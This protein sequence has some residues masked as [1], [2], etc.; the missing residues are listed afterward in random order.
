MR[1]ATEITARIGLDYQTKTV[2]PGALFYQ[3]CLPAETLFY[4]LVF[5]NASRHQ[6]HKK[7]AAQIMGYLRENTPP[8]LQVGGDETT[9]KG[10]CVVRLTNGKGGVQ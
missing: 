5:A 2:R 4:S 7:T 9:G 6:E 10:L 1:H 8:V 3:E